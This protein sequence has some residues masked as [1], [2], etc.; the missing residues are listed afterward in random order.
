MSHSNRSGRK[1]GSKL[2]KVVDFKNITNADIFLSGHSHDLTTHKGGFIDIS[3]KGVLKIKEQLFVNCG[4]FQPYAGYIVAH[5]FSPLPNGFAL[6]E[7]NNTK[8]DAK[9]LI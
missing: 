9:V 1:E 7:L 8:N 3:H 4:A 5:N 2:Q 6:L